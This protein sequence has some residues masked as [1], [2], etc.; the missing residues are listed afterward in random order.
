[1]KLIVTFRN[2]I[3]SV[4]IYKTSSSTASVKIYKTSSSTSNESTEINC[5]DHQSECRLEVEI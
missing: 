4:K 1:M 2:F 5:K 3:K